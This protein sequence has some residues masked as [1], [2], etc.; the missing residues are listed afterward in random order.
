[1][2]CNF[3]T[4]WM[5]WLDRNRVKAGNL[6]KKVIKPFFLL[7]HFVSPNLGPKLHFYFE[8]SIKETTPKHQERAR[9]VQH[10]LN[11]SHGQSV[12]GSALR[13]HKLCVISC[14]TARDCGHSL[15]SRSHPPTP[16]P[17]SGRRRQRVSKPCTWDAQMPARRLWNQEPVFQPKSR[18]DKTKAEP[19]FL[20]LTSQGNKIASPP[21]FTAE[22]R[23]QRGK[24]WLRGTPPGGNDPLCASAETPTWQ[25]SQ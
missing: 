1:M 5:E 16:R 3:F 2:C 11:A 18:C 19:L 22:G 25:K 20:K 7:T 13:W 21:V 10:L 15:Y 23:G 4:I 24:A 6:D 17:L 12:V 8:F 14:G 9:S